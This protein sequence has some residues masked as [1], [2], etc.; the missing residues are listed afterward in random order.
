MT[1]SKCAPS[2]FALNI[3]CVRHCDGPAIRATR[4]TLQKLRG[5]SAQDNP[6]VCSRKHVVATQATIG[7]RGFRP[8]ALST[9]VLP[10]LRVHKSL[11]AR[12]ELGDELGEELLEGEE[13]ATRPGAQPPGQLLAA[14][15][16][17]VAPPCRKP[18]GVYCYS[19]VGV[20]ATADER[21]TRGTLCL[22]PDESERK[23]LLLEL[24]PSIPKPPGR[25]SSVAPPQV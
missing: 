8:P 12:L 3:H 13:L 9:L 17:P 4:D 7:R 22:S 18:R 19:L 21:A 15:E 1:L 11:V 25:E 14:V 24:R 10:T 16:H 2:P 5:V 6:S 20:G 23:V